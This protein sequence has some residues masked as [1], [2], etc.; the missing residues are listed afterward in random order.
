VQGNFVAQRCRAYVNSI[1]KLK[2]F[3]FRLLFC[4][5]LGFPGLFFCGG[6]FRG[7][8]PLR[9]VHVKV[10]V[11]P[12]FS[13]TAEWR[14]IVTALFEKADHTLQECA[15]VKL[16]VDSMIIW[17]MESAPSHT[18]LLIG[19]C[20]VKEQPRGS[21]DIVV[22]FARMG[23][24]PALISGMTL[25]ELGYAYLQQPTTMNPAHID[26]KAV[27]SL[28][29]WLGHMFGAAHCYFDKEKIT[30]MNPFVHDGIIMTSKDTDAPMAPVFHKGNTGLM[31]CLSHRPFEEKEWNRKLWPKI[32]QVYE[33]VHNDYNPWTIDRDGEIR[34]YEKD[35]FHEGNLILYLSSWASLCGYPDV[36]IRYLDSLVFL[37]TAVTNK[38]VR[39]GVVGKTR[40]CVQCGYGKDEA[41]NWLEQQKFF[42]GMRRAVILLRKGDSTTA[43]A[44]FAAAIK[45]IP[46]QLAMMKDKYSNGYSFY[47]ERYC[48]RRDSGDAR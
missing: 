2:F 17:D 33:K 12:S 38:C 46:D 19:D 36:A 7:T 5:G 32:K 34:N 21:S 31:R 37:Y 45:G 13:T 29:H 16:L 20:L 9:T 14:A 48:V 26:E 3:R 27:S 25:Y 23:N 22:Y 18:D 40:I 15:G 35:A 44:C 41:S 1:R 42:I 4:I 30:V 24:P 39:E 10:V 47:K 6:T 11:D 28:V 8:V 43:N